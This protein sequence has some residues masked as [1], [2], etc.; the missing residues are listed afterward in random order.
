MPPPRGIWEYSPPPPLGRYGGEMD[1]DRKQPGRGGV[2]KPSYIRSRRDD[3][4]SSS[5]SSS[6]DSS[7]SS[8]SADKK[9]RKKKH[10]KVK[11]RAPADPS[12]TE[13]DAEGMKEL[14]SMAASM[15]KKQ[16]KIEL[17]DTVG[18]KPLPKVD[19]SGISYG[20]NLLAGEAEGMARFVQDN[21]RIPRRGEIGLTSDQIAAYEDVGFV[22]SGSRHRRM[23]AVRMRKESQIYSAEEAKALAALNFEEKVQKE[24]KILAG[25]RQILTKKLG[26][27]GGGGGDTGSGGD[28]SPPQAPAGD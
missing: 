2:E 3:V 27:G 11:K 20:G 15:E 1:Q 8:S 16:A 22:M 12:R 6:S 21:K 19:V 24:T 5:S 23:N 13:R 26:S 14:S 10:K 17:D 28:E 4:E 9:T 18:P 25:F 7:S